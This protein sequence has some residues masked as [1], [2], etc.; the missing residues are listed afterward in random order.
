MAWWE[1]LISGLATLAVAAMI[2]YV[3]RIGLIQAFGKKTMEVPRGRN[4]SEQTFVLDEKARNRVKW[5]TIISFVI[6]LACTGACAW[7]F[8]TLLVIPSS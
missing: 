1:I 4:I 8:I 7:N 2:T 3:A 5:G 6:I